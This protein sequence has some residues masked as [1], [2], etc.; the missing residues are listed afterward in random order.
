VKLNVIRLGLPIVGAPHLPCPTPRSQQRARILSQRR[1]ITV[2]DEAADKKRRQEQQP[3]RS[4]ELHS[5]NNRSV[6]DF[7]SNASHLARQTSAQAKREARKGNKTVLPSG[8]SSADRLSYIDRSSICRSPS[9]RSRGEAHSRPA[10]SIS[11]E[12]RSHSC[13]L[14]S[15]FVPF[16]LPL[17]ATYGF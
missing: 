1:G 3:V 12:H 6:L 7:N 5:P 8:T 16:A 4:D 10:T 9:L 17:R 11:R 15:K 13:D 14:A 2:V